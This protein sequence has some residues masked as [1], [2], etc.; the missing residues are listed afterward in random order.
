MSKSHQDLRSRIQINDGPEVI[1]DKIRLALTDSM[2]GV[3][4][5]PKHRPG[6]SNLLNIVSYLDEQHRTAQELAQACRS[7]DM[8]R[9]KAMVATSISE[10]LAN[11]Q[12]KYDRIMNNYETHYLD[13]ISIDGSDKARQQA[14]Q[15]M[16]SVRQVTGLERAGRALEGSFGQRH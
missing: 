5:D 6:V 13:D 2:P 10:S 11:I 4:Y 12:G 3:S 15:I 14:D 1:A 7:M 16:A 8:R 9:F